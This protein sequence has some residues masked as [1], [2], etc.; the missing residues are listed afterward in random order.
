MRPLLLLALATT[1]L[2]VEPVKYN[3]QLDVVSEGFDGKFCWFHPR[4]GAI[5][6]ESPVVVLTMQRWRLAACDVFYPVA[7]QT[8]RD[9]GKTA[10]DKVNGLVEGLGEAARA[11]LSP[12]P[13]A[14]HPIAADRCALDYPADVTPQAIVDAITRA[15]GRLVSLSPL[16][17]TLEDFFVSH[18]N[19]ADWERL[20]PQ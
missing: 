12:V 2:A 16:R 4:A 20:G 7:S 18:V 15:G 6:G 3:V 11:H 1:A 10:N 17:D 13:R 14:I 8:T 5:P 9:Y 19:A